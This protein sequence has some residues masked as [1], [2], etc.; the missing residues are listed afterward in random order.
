MSHPLI[1]RLMSVLPDN[2]RRDDHD[3]VRRDGSLKE[4]FYTKP[5]LGEREQGYGQRGSRAVLH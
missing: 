2:H 4:I 5:A 3:D 1:D